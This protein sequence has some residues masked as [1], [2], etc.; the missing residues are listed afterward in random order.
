MY[1]HDCKLPPATC[2]VL[3]SFP[4]TIDF[5]SLNTLIQTVNNLIVCPG[6]PDPNLVRMIKAKKCKICSPDGSVAA[7][8]DTMPVE[9]SGNQY[10]ETIRTTACEVLTKSVKCSAC[11]KYRPSLRSMHHRWS[12]HIATQLSASSDYTNERYLNTPEKSTKMDRLK[13]RVRKAELTVKSLS[14]KVKS[15]TTE[16]GKSLDK[17]FEKDLMSI[18]HDNHQKVTEAY[19][20]GSFARLFWNEQLKAATASDNRRV[21]WHPVIIKWCLNLKLLSSSSYYALRTSGFIKLPSERTLFDYT[22][23]F[24]NAVGFDQV[25]KQLCDEISKMSIPESRMFVSVILD[26]MKIKEGLVYNKHSGEIVG[27]TSLGDINDDLVQV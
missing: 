16:Q 17:S 1:V 4:T 6:H 5:E 25:N 11:T 3:R 26:K 10:L 15:L 22:H 7:L 14:N 21:R 20:D 8:L 13:S 19:P 24:A 27:F 23:Y 2:S 12:K 18:M 9:L